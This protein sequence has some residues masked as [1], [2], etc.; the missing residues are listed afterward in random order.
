M[1]IAYINKPYYDKEGFDG[2]LVNEK[3]RVFGVFDGMGVSEGA[4]AIAIMIGNAINHHASLGHDCKQMAETINATA[5][6]SAAHY[7]HDGS[8]ATVVRVTSD[9]VL[10]YAHV[11]DSRLYVYRRGRIKQITA[12]EGIGNLLLNYVGAYSHGV[13]QIG[14]IEAEDWDA[15][16]LCTDGITGDFKDQFIEDEQIERVFQD[17]QTSQEICND[18]VSMSKKDDD[19]TIIVVSKFKGENQ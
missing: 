1:D 6:T 13:N 16:M 14:Q 9:G 11:G 2:F 3:H 17:R 7:P 12:D 5:R 10:E 19:K 15:F 8:T 18:L 4:R